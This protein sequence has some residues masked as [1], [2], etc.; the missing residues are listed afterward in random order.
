MVK[1]FI[2]YIERGTWEEDIERQFD[3]LDGFCWVVIIIAA[4][5]FGPTFLRV[6]MQEVSR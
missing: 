6:I 1:K 4:I 2:N 5:Y 3:L